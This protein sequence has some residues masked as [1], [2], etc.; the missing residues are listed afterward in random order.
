VTHFLGGQER[1]I[2][3]VPIYSGARLLG[4]QPVRLLNAD[5]AFAFTAVTAD[6]ISMADHLRRFLKHT[7]LRFI[8]WVNFN[9][10]QIEF[11]TL[12]R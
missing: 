8:Q 2:T 7:P 3:P 1:V 6:R 12:A 5:T 11:T 9:H 4:K 10:H